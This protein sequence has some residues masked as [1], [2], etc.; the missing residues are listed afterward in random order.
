MRPQGS[1]K[2][3]ERR[4]FRAIALLEKGY[5]P[6]D[7]AQMVGVERRSVRRWKAACLKEGHDAIKS[8]PTPGRPQKLN[9]KQINK[10]EHKLLKGAKAAGFATDLWTC[11]RITQLIQNSFGV[12]YHVDHIGRLLRSMGWSP[13]K[14]QRRAIE[15]DE[16][17]IQRWIKEEWP[18]IKK[19][20]KS[21]SVFNIC[22]RKRYVDGATRPEK[23]GSLGFDPDS[24]ST[25]LFS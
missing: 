1:P 13:Q 8:N 2:E 23:L 19:S 4:R 16:R 6:V 21:E 18:R 11:P 5:M 22:R 7:V 24:F 14:P 9:E 12:Q 15:R 25:Y 10:L 20:L 17:E 3:L